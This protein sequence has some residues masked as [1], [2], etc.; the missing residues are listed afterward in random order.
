M[1][2]NVCKYWQKVTDFFYKEMEENI[3]HSYFVCVYVYILRK[4]RGYSISNYTWQ[5]VHNTLKKTVTWH[6]LELIITLSALLL[7]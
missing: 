7:H 6:S 4:T 2:A 3:F 5:K 1:E